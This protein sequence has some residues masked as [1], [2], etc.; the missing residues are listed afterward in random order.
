[1]RPK[2]SPSRT[3]SDAA[4]SRRTKSMNR[5]ARK[6]LRGIRRV[7]AATAR[8]LRWLTRSASASGTNNAAAATMPFSSTGISSTRAR[9]RSGAATAVSSATL[10]PSD[11]PP[12]TAS[13]AP[14]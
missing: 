9:T 8:M 12:T 13:S 1:M 7:N 10:A 3:A 14:R 2:Q 11:V 5:S 4:G 6:R